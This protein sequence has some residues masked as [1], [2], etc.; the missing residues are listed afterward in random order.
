MTFPALPR[1]SPAARLAGRCAALCA[2][3]AL[4]ASDLWATAAGA[5][6]WSTAAANLRT[7]FSGPIVTGLAVVCVVLGGLT[8]A[9][10]EGQSKKQLAGMVFGLGMAL[11]AVPFLNWITP[12]G[13]TVAPAELPGVAVV[14]SAPVAAPRSRRRLP[15]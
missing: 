9:F 6:P 11:A 3:A 12:T 1:S 8:F 13:T 7:L 15:A 14:A 4:G 5:D 10:G 2:L